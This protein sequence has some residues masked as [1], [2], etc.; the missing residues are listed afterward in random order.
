ML[1]FCYFLCCSACSFLTFPEEYKGWDME[2]VAWVDFLR[3][4]RVDSSR[5]IVSPQKGRRIQVEERLRGK[6]RNSFSLQQIIPYGTWDEASRDQVQKECLPKLFL[7]SVSRSWAVI[8][9][10]NK[11]HNNILYIYASM[12]LGYFASY[13]SLLWG[14]VVF[15]ISVSNHTRNVREFWYDI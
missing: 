1:S 13:K 11:S 12:R 4:M 6:W 3:V 9:H 2:K 15:L 5:F 8:S 10:L 7:F 14:C